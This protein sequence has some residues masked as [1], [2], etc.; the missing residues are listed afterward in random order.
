MFQ[1]LSWL[2]LQHRSHFRK[3]AM[4]YKCIYGLCPEYLCDTFHANHDIHNHKTIH[5]LFRVTKHAK[6]RSAYYHGSLASQMLCNEVPNNIKRTDV[7]LY[8]VFKMPCTSMWFLSHNCKMTL[9]HNMFLLISIY[10]NHVNMYILV[11][12]CM[13][14]NGL[15]I[16]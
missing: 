10:S 1:E 11:D 2:Y 13:W 6:A 12:S 14:C 8:L 4:A 3:I 7:Y 16:K 5:A 15:A 9:T